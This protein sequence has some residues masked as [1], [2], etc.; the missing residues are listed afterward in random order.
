[1]G[2]GGLGGSTPKTCWGMHLLD[3]IMILQGFKPTIQSLGVGYANRPKEGGMWH[4]P[5]YK[6]LC[7]F[8]LTTFVR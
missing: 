5:L 3:K 1:M 8:D 4:F 7:G 6:G 2:G